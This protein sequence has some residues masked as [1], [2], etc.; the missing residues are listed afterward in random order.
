MN[1]STLK[2]FLRRLQITFDNDSNG[3]ICDS[4]QRAKATKVYNQE[5]QRR[6]QRPYQFI[7]TDLVRPI[8]PVG[9]VGERYFFTFTDN[10]TRLTK[11]YIGAKKSDWLKCLKTYHSLCRTRSKEEHPIERLQSDYGSELQSHKADEWIQKEGITFEP[12]AP[13]SQ[14]QNGVSERMGRTIMD[15]TRAK[16]LEG[17]IDDDLWPELIIN[18]TYIKNCRPTRALNNLSPHKAHFHKQLN[19]THLRVLGSTVYVLLHE[20]ERSMKSEKWTP[21]ALKETLVGYN[22]HTI[23]RIYIKE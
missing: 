16:I 3:L 10:C 13:Y 15:I 23:Y 6:A 19:L 2:T 22:G 14:E 8:K 12:S 1:F 18:T 21:R 5:P 4:C 11:T 20:E 17:N 7:H 9:F